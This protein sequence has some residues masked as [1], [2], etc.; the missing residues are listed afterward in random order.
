VR[1]IRLLQN[2]IEIGM[3]QDLTPLYGDQC[4]EPAVTQ[5]SSFES[6]DG[7]QIQVRW[8]LIYS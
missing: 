6:E 3:Y 2:I 7:F 4:N 1:E 8:L 5:Q